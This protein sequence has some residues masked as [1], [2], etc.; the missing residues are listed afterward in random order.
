ML[1]S[2]LKWIIFL[3]VPHFNHFVLSIGA[4]PEHEIEETAEETKKREI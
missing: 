3:I 2:L 4:V 1:F